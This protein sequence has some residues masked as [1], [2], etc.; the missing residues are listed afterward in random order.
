MYALNKQRI[1]S[2]WIILVRCIPSAKCIPVTNDFEPFGG[3][4]RGRQASILLL[5][6]VLTRRIEP[7]TLWKSINFS[8][9]TNAFIL[10]ITFH[11]SISDCV[12]N[13]AEKVQLHLGLNVIAGVMVLLHFSS[14]WW[15]LLRFDCDAAST[16][17]EFLLDAKL[18]I[19]KMWY[20]C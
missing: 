12:F 1:T 3:A 6:P 5:F 4:G 7:R 2:N 15:F 14:V 13:Q 16:T 20:A 19:L 9:C 10:E 18:Y 17:V 11:F 8:L